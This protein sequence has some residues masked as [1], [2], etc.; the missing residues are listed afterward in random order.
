MFTIDGVT[1]RPIESD[2]IDTMYDWHLDF[3]IDMYSS[4]G[5]KRSREH[6]KERLQK[7]LMNPPDDAIEFGIEIDK[8]LIGRVKLESIDRLNRRA[9]LGVNIGNPNAR[10]QGFGKSTVR[11]MLDYAF[12]VENL[13]KVYA[14]T[15]GF[16]VRSQ[17][18]LESVGFIKEGLLRKHEVHNGDRHD[19]HFF[20]ILKDEFYERYETLFKLSESKE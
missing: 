1:L 6:F 19:V 15:Y 16:N 14:E 3:D 20:G 11:I 17:K 10:N 18:C 8:G 7:A 12:K 2:E 13:E 4:W 5:K 9:S